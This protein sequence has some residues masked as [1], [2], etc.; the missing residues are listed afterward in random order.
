MKISIDTAVFCQ[1]GYCGHIRYLILNPSTWQLTHLAIKPDGLPSPYT[2]LVRLLPLHL[3]TEV[4]ARAISLRCT[5]D[6]FA[7]CEP[8][9]QAY[10]I[11]VDIPPDEITEMSVWTSPPSGEQVVVPVERQ[12]VPPGEVAISR[13]TQVEATDGHIG[14]FDQLIVNREDGL[15]T[16]F[17][18]RRGHLWEQRVVTVPTT[19]IIRVEAN[20]IY[21]KLDKLG[22]IRLPST[23]VRT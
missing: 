6:T 3:I 13:E 20:A 17:C 7:R 10:Y 12:Y 2:P 8:F 19:D 5:I 14:R 11:K 18:F 22:V 23:P 16:H 9:I 1:D 4:Q 15:I 21:L